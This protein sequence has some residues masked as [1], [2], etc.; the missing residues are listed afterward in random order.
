M[1]LRR[2]NEMQ[3]EDALLSQDSWSAEM[4]GPELDTSPMH[5]VQHDH[6]IPNTTSQELVRW[7]M[8]LHVIGY[9]I[10]VESYVYS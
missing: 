8:S 1:S 4:I 2:K 3:M 10:E 7:G 6:G 5:P 9:Y